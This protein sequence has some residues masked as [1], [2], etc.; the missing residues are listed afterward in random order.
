MKIAF[1]S[2]EGKSGTTSNMLACA[3]MFSILYP[4]VKVSVQSLRVLKRQMQTKQK[5]QEEEH[6]CFLD[7]GNGLD[8]RKRRV[9]SQMDMVVVNL[10]QEKESLDRFFMD[11]VHWV[12]DALVLVGNYYDSSAL[13]RAYLENVYRIAPEGLGTISSN[14][15]FCHACQLAKV[16]RF[17]KTEY[18]ETK[19][20]R[21]KQLLEELEQFTK[22]IVMRMEEKNLGRNMVWNR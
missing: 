18:A 19:S 3:A 21:N 16:R 6:I 10:K 20:M 17:I 13:N 11:D 8:E 7:C 12:P 1:W 15:E 2:E 4:H 14:G 5:R 9:L 22:Q